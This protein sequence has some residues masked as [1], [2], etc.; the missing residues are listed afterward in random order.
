MPNK[1]NLKTKRGISG[2]LGGHQSKSL[3]RLS[4][5]W[6]DWHQIWYTSADSSG[7]GH[8][9]NSI[10]PSTFGDGG[11]GVRNSKVRGRCETAGPIGTKF[12]T[13]GQIH[14]GMDIRQMNCSKRH[15][16][17]SGGFRGSNIQKSGEAV[18]RLGR[19]APTLVHVCGFIWEWAFAKYKA[20]LNTPGGM[21]GGWVGG[22]GVT[23]S[24]VLGGSCHRLDRL[25]PNL[26][27]VCG[28]LWKW[29]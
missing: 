18:K 10:Y 21:S 6:T 29:T 13:H 26:V 27:H 16:G 19:L 1:L 28:F 20:P 2:V 7:N 4:N 9:L 22:L 25:A 17:A 12:G 11:L 23:N 8:R 3:G 15:K 5:G 24:K 14:L